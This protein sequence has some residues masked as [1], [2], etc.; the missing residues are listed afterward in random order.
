MVCSSK[1]GSI[2]PCGI[3]MYATNLA[4][5]NTNL[6]AKVDKLNKGLA[7]CF[8]GSATLDRILREQR[9]TLG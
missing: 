2:A 6:K 1:E 4:K 5:E 3:A 8:K 7:K 9:Y